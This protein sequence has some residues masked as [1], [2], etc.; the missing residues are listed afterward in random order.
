MTPRRSISIA[1]Q[2]AIP[3]LAFR[4][5]ENTPA[6]AAVLA[7]VHAGRAEADGLDPFST[8]DSLATIE[9]LRTALA[10]AAASGQLERWLLAE[11][12]GQAVG[13]AVLESWHEEDGRWVY[14]V[15]AA[16]LP[17]WRRRG[18]G[19]ALLR[20]G[21][22]LSARL[23]PLE[24]PGALWELAGMVSSAQPTAAELLRRAGYQPAY[25]DL[26]M[27]LDPAADWAE[28]PLPPGLEL[29]PALPEHVPLVG[30]SIAE[31]YRAE[32][33]ASRFRTTQMETAGQT[34][35]YSDPIHDRSLWQVAWDGEQIAGQVLP[36]FERGCAV[37]DEV[38]V[39][40]P[41][42]RRGLARALL[43]RA[44]QAVRAHGAPRVRL[45]TV[46]E[47]PTRARDLYASLGFQVIKSLYHFRKTPRSADMSDSML[48]SLF[49][50]NN[51]AN[52]QVIRACASLSAAQ[53]DAEP[54]SATRGTIRS[55][56]QHLVAAQNNY[57]R[58]LTLPR[59]E[60]RERLPD[61]PFEELEA[62]AAASGEA[63]LALAR[64]EAALA[65]KGRLLTR[66]GDQVE[67]WVIMLQVINHATEHREQVKS[68]LTALGVTPPSVDGWDYG[69]AV[70]AYS[71]A[72][73]P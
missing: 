57:V 39:R 23:A 45:Y 4:H 38:S 35:W 72:Q 65:A 12:D 44:L 33:P 62:V 17:A 41:W 11:V 50:H 10:K 18:L 52:A 2:P 34:E 61:P 30:A 13:C 37:I 26:E 73:Q 64:D 60:R 40:P 19:T 46:A 25:T 68:M 1:G 32:F 56:L 36:V 9:E 53:L 48:A 5:P 42:R 54:H 71:T 59:E 43:V 55:T 14:Q 15:N 70:G 28:C 21:E 27:E 58:T 47:F 49:A 31:A 16:V 22:A 51:W 24:H 63:L 3:G 29:R 6:D 67:P 7:A 66:D 69:M 8:I 20:W